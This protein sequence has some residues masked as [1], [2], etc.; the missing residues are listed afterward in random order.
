MRR[1]I[2][3]KL[4]RWKT[5]PI[6]KPLVLRGARQV[7]K[8]WIIKKFGHD[9]FEDL[10]LVDLE[11]NRQWHGFFSESLDPRVIIQGIELVTRKK[12]VPGK[13]LLFFDEIQACPR[14]VMSLRY[15]FEELPDLHVIAAGSLL[16]FILHDISFPVGRVHHLHMYPMTFLEFLLARGNET[17]SG[18]IDRP[19]AQ[20]PDAQHETLLQELKRYFLVGGM[21]GCIVAFNQ[22]ESVADVFEVQA[23]LI[24]SFIDDFGKY[25]GHADKK[26]LEDVFRGISKGIGSQVT[27]STLTREFTHPTIKKALTLLTKAK[28][29]HPVPSVGLIEHPLDIGTSS[30]KFKAL[31]LDIGIWQHLSGITTQAELLTGDLMNFYRG[32]LAEQFVGQEMI[33]FTDNNLHYWARNAKSSNAEVDYVVEWKGKLFPLEVKSGESGSLKSLHMAL[34]T[35][36]HCPEGVVFSTRRYSEIPSQKLRFIPLYYAGTWLNHV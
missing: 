7:G 36:S 32:A 8:T 22:S 12:I 29:V 30:K 24:T 13:T 19:P 4:L 2:E 23:D 1:L 18:I 16:E 17:A 27:Y 21:P 6:R 25:A 9:H 28:I 14:A 10:V 3:S 34:S 20:L 11:K 35:F 26:C 15:F 31:L 33:A 5:S